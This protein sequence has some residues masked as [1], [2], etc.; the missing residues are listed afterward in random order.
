MLNFFITG[1]SGL[2]G[3]ALYKTLAEKCPGLCQGSYRTRARPGLLFLDIE[4][5]EAAGE[6]FQRLKPEVVIHCACNAYVDYCQEHQE[7]AYRANVLGTEN[8][9][10]ACARVGA[11]L[12]FLSTDY[13]FDGRSGPYSEDAPP[14]PISYYGWTK[15]KGEEIVAK[16]E[17]G[18]LIFRTAWVYGQ[19]RDEKNFVQRLIQNNQ[20]R[21]ETQVPSDQFNSPTLVNNLVEAAIEL[22]SAGKSGIYH[23]AGSQVLDRYSFSLLAADIFG[24]DKSLILPKRTSELN[25]PAPRPLKGGLDIFKAKRELKTKLMSP[26]EGLKAFKAEL[27]LPPS[28]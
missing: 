23:L 5:R 16:N 8:V 1:A 19:D 26:E 20:K 4:D 17:A 2:V 9:T 15:L 24:L 11:R 3:G 14:H 6:A 22:I 12:V 28:G 27:D 18:F 10:L 7:E 13:I 25:Q 21:V